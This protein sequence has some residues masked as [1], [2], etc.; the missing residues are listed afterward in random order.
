MSVSAKKLKSQLAELPTRDRAELA[1][2]LILSL[3]DGADPD[4]ELLWDAELNRREQ[5]IREGTAR[6]E[7]W[8]KVAAA[9]RKK[10]S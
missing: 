8:D 6:G 7:P 4:A 1:H 2:F 5:E 9:L 3:E 10:Y